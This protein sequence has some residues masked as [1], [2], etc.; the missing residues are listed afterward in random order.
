[1]LVT[2][3]PRFGR[4][5]SSSEPNQS[6]VNAIRR[7]PRPAFSWIGGAVWVIADEEARCGQFGGYCAQLVTA[8]AS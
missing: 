3:Q 5:H 7:W 6:L 2:N 1:V 8:P 4:Y